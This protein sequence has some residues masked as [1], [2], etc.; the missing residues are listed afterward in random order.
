MANKGSLTRQA[1]TVALAID[2]ALKELNVTQEQVSIE[3]LEEGRKGFL[4]IGAKDA[5]VR[6]TV[7]QEAASELELQDL[8]VDLRLN[9]TPDA[10]NSKEPVQSVEEQSEDPDAIKPGTVAFTGGRLVVKNP[11][12][13]ESYAVIKVGSN[14]KVTVNGQLVEVESPVTQEDDIN[15]EVIHDEPDAYLNLTV[16]KDKVEAFLQLITKPGAGYKILDLPPSNRVT[17]KAVVDEILEPEELTVEDVKAFL[18]SKGVVKGIDED[19]I[20]QLLLTPNNKEP[21]LVAVGQRPVNGVHAKVRYPFLE[22]DGTD[23]G[24]VF[25]NDKLV[26]VAQGEVIAIKVP[27]EEGQDGWDVY[28]EVIQAKGP[29]DC[30]INV[31][32]GCELSTD[33]QTA[34]AIISG[35]PVL[36]NVAQRT[37][38]AVEPIY[39]VKE[40]NAAT[41]DIRFAGDVEVKGDVEGC[42][43]AAQGNVEILGDVSRATIIAGSSVFIHKMIF[44]SEVTAGGRSAV[45]LAILPLMQE[46]SG[47]VSDLIEQAEYLIKSGE[48][49]NGDNS[50]SVGPL[51]QSLVDKRFKELPQKVIQLVGVALSSPVPITEDA[52]K[53]VNQLNNSFC[54]VGP[55]G[56]TRLSYLRE[57]VDELAE[58]AE[59]A[60]G[61]IRK[62]DCIKAKY[63]QNST[64]KSSGDVFIEGQGCY[65]TTVE[66]GGKVTVCG[67]PGVGRGIKVTSKG[68]VCV[69]DLGSDLDNHTSIKTFKGRVRSEVLHPDVVIHIDRAKFRS[70]KVYKDFVAVLDEEGKIIIG[71]TSV[72]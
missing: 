16:S 47:H 12:N 40:V 49:E 70:E 59:F 67:K 6:V 33:G 71:Q 3:V 26:S 45:C 24:V 25:E 22:H 43:I 14:V 52:I 5:K 9:E 36:E 19:A 66:A 7:K 38:L 50:P 44:S 57:L 8:L 32:K 62:S 65:I 2:K 60:K 34:I 72:E 64:L 46:I 30:E 35:R 63:V 1:K 48:G 20:E 58:F 28:G 18:T 42:T 56:I 11:Q 69:R 61:Y 29:V 51:L 23:E 4:G 21:F 41:G 55:V 13:S 68:D 27:K 31:K 54:G 53:L 39:S 37:Y 17:L 10:A 15:I